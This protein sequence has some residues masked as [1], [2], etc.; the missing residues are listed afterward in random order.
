MTEA[1]EPLLP[2]TRASLC[3]LYAPLNR[4]LRELLAAER[5][6]CDGAACDG[7]LWAED[8]L[9]PMMRRPELT[10]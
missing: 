1:R 4:Q 7:F 8:C 5:T 2:A 9:V 10:I 6:S 3:R